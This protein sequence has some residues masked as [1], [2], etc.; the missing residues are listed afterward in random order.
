MSSHI[1]CLL[2]LG[3]CVLSCLQFLL[4]C[5]LVLSSLKPYPSAVS[6]VVSSCLVLSSPPM[7]HLLT[8]IMQ[9]LALACGA[10]KGAPRQNTYVTLWDMANRRP[11]VISHVGPGSP[12][13]DGYAFGEPFPMPV[14]IMA[15]G[16]YALTVQI[17]PG[18]R[19]VPAHSTIH[20][21]SEFGKFMGGVFSRGPWLYPSERD[22]HAW[23]QAYVV[24]IS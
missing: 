24:M 17:A 1:P 7:I 5:P 11:I 2:C 6:S 10:G 16:L 14:K 19:L 15:G 23:E 8:S 22:P 12:I 18:L 4:F 13:E 3:T 9:V 20:I 21:S